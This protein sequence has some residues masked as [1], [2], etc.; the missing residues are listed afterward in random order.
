MT[1]RRN[2]FVSSGLCVAIFLMVT[3]LGV[4]AKDI[5]F[6]AGWGGQG[7][8]TLAALCAKFTAQTG[9]KATYEKTD[10]VEALIR[11]RIAGGNSPDV[12]LQTR[13]AVIGELVQAGNLARLDGPARQGGLQEG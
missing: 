11:T 5:V 6:I 1:F 7:G 2:R 8:D 10:D 3:T 9:I 12:A 4:S 13:P